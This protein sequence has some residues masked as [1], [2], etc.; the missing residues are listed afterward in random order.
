M[1]NPFGVETAGHEA[2]LLLDDD[3][4]TTWL[5]THFISTDPAVP[6]PSRSVLHFTMGSAEP[7]ASYELVTGRD[8]PKRDP[9]SWALEVRGIDGEFA[10]VWRKVSEYHGYILSPK[11]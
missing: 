9:V 1:Y 3:D 5:D 11:S 10:N 4:E 8:Q 2:S 6:S 7:V